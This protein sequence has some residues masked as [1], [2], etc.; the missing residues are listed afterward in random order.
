MKKTIG[1]RFGRVLLRVLAPFV[2]CLY[3]FKLIGKENVPK[4]ERPLVVCSNHISM[5][6][7]IFLMYAFKQPI[8]FMGKDS[9]FKNKI[10]GF[11]LR[12]WFGVFPVTRGKGDQT[13]INKAFEVVEKGS[14]LGIFPE[15]T[16]SKDGQLGQ[17][18]SGTAMIIAKTQANVLP[19]AVFNKE[20]TRLKRFH[21]T[22]VVV[23]KIMTPEELQLTG[24]KPNIRHASRTIMATI[25]SMIEENNV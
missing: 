24:E 5:M 7:P 25:E 8:Y 3:P 14:A 15:G 19:C 13:A 17:P 20:R 22:T 18:K 11:I 2:F 4:E 10:I 6:D 16:R 9:L 1:I 21:R 12:S 23:G